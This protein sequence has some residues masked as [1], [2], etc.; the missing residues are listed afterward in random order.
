MV[1]PLLRPSVLRGFL[2]VF[3]RCIRETTITLMLYG[4]GTQ[5]VAV[6]LWFLW[7]QD[8]DTPL[9]SAIAIPMVIVAAILTYFVARGT[10]LRDKVV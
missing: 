8:T 3:V 5:T 10:M 9:A 2:W 6:T 4:V 1:L 7:V